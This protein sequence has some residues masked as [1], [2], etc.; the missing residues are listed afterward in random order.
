MRGECC[1]N[2]K[3]ECRLESVNRVLGVTKELRNQI[4]RSL[5][6]QPDV[7]SSV[8]ETTDYNITIPPPLNSNTKNYGHRDYLEKV[9]IQKY[10]NVSLVED[11]GYWLPN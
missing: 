4:F 3:S 10:P 1:L 2:L 9:K 5:T 11:S 8:P 7:P 6:A